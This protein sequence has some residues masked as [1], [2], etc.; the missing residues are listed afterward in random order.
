MFIVSCT[1]PIGPRVVPLAVFIHS[2]FFIMSSV[3][4][5]FVKSWHEMLEYVAQ[6]QKEL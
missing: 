2:A 1:I 5:Y 3:S 4:N 6:C